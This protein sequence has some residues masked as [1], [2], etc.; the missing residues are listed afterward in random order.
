MPSAKPGP[1]VSSHGI[2]LVYENKTRGILLTL[3][4]EI[5]HA[6][7]P[8]SYKHLDKIRTAYAEKRHL[9]FTCYG[10]RQ[11]CLPCPRS[12]HQEH[13]FWDPPS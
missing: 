2:N 4:K 7:G 6:R 9:C 13:A 10:A 12:P 3:R 11:E 8:H 5:S 1:T